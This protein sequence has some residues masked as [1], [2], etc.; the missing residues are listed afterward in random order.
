MQLTKTIYVYAALIFV[1]MLILINSPVLNSTRIGVQSQVARLLNGEVRID[2][3]DYEYL[4]FKGRVY[5]N[6]ALNEMLIN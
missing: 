2:K 3:L 5:G 4:R 6:D 1:A